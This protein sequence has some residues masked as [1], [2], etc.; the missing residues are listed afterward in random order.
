MIARLEESDK[1]KAKRI[2]DL[3]AVVVIP[4]LPIEAQ[5]L[6]QEWKDRFSLCQQS[7]V[8]DGKI[9]FSL[10][11]KYEAELSL[12][13]QVCG[14]LEEYK[15]QLSRLTEQSQAQSQVN[16]ILIRKLRWNKSLRTGTTLALVGAVAYL[17]LKK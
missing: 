17:V 10:S 1:A 7:R 6:I 5:E 16:Q 2:R 3:E 11:K 15:E 12:R 9:I 4:E 8:E 14:L 13:L